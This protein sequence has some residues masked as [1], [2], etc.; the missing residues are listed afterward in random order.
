[1]VRGFLT[2]IGIAV[3]LGTTAYASGAQEERKPPDVAAMGR[4]AIQ[5]VRAREKDEG[6]P[7][8]QRRNPRYQLSKGDIF[9]LTFPF[10]A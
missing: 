2:S 3:L 7:E 9:D 8:L 1:M 4:A 10:N 6:P 5:N